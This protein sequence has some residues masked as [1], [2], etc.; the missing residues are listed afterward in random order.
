MDHVPDGPTILSVPLQALQPVFLG[1]ALVGCP[2]VLKFTYTLPVV[3][4]TCV[5]PNAMGV[6]V[7]WSRRLFASQPLSPTRA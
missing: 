3:P 2:K 7:G 1:L 6:L 4:A 5:V